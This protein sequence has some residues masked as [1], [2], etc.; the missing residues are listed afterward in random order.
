MFAVVG[1]NNPLVDRCGTVDSADT[2]CFPSPSG[3]LNSVTEA[4][5]LAGDCL[6][7][8]VFSKDSNGRKTIEGC[9]PRAKL[10]S[11]TALGSN[12]TKS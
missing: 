2:D 8:A 7:V 9:A 5:L 3:V 6:G 10:L 11:S 1:V 12:A 4:G